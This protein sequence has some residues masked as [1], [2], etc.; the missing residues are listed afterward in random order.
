MV[1]E[2]AA[3]AFKMNLEDF[4]QK[5]DYASSC[6]GCGSSGSLIVKQ[7]T[8]EAAFT[9]P[10]LNKTQP[11]RMTSLLTIAGSDVWISI[12]QYIDIHVTGR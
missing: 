7:I 4:K 6:D 1:R 8:K 5:Q 3:I 10:L 12:F 9:K 2:R 11:G